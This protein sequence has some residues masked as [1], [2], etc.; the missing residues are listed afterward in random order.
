MRNVSLTLQKYNNEGTIDAE[1]NDPYVDPETWTADGPTDQPIMG[2]QHSS[3]KNKKNK[4][5]S[6]ASSELSSVTANH[7]HNQA[8]PITN[9]NQNISS[10]QPT[11]TS[12]KDQEMDDLPHNVVDHRMNGW[13]TFVPT[14]DGSSYVPSEESSRRS[15]IANTVDEDADLKRL[16]QWSQ[17]AAPRSAAPVPVTTAPATATTAP[18]PVTTAARRTKAPAPVPV[19]AVARTTA[20]IPVIIEEHIPDL[21]PKTHKIR[22]VYLWCY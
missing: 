17:S 7:N 8:V 15:S 3:K 21:P 19:A 4:R 9:Y 13:T 18:A 10:H 1:E 11:I 20:P 22:Y 14:T 2:Q 5:Q 6:G 12:A 16:S